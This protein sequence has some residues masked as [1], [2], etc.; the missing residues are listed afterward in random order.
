VSAAPHNGPLF[1]F[2]R[3]TLASL[4]VL[5]SINIWT[6]GPLLALWAGSRADQGNGLTM[7]TV[8]I[9]VATLFAVVFALAVLLTRLGAAYDTLTG[10]PSRRARATWLRSLGA[11]RVTTKGHASQLSL[12]EKVMVASVVVAVLIFEGWF[13]F[14]AELQLPAAAGLRTIGRRGIRFGVEVAGASVVTGASAGVRRSSDACTEVSL[15]RSC[16]RTPSS[17]SVLSSRGLRSLD[18]SWIG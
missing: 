1:W 6:G 15:R 7:S 8:G 12:L 18:F 9:V 11:E 10:R 2:K 16:A 17:S 3:V 13:F 5:T 14:L 4:I